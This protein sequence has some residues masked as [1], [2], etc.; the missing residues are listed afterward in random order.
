MGRLVHLMVLFIKTTQ[1]RSLPGTPVRLN[2][3][4]GKH[5]GDTALEEQQ[6]VR[7][8]LLSL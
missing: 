4:V 7:S 8:V 2:T 6:Q 3:H 5:Y 1:R